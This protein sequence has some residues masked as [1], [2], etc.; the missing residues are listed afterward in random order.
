MTKRAK[1]GLFYL[2][3]LGSLPLGFLYFWGDVVSWVLKKVLK[4]RY[5]VVYTNLARSFPEKKYWELEPIADQFYTHL[6]ELFAE[7]VWFGGCYR[8]PERLRRQRL[9]EVANQELFNQVYEASPSVT[10]LTSHCGNWEILGGICY[11]NYN[12][13][14]PVIPQE[15]LYVAYKQLH[16]KVSDEIFY[17]N[18]RGV[19]TDYQGMLESN[20]IL[21]F[22][23]SHRKEKLAYF[24]I[25]DQYPDLMKAQLDGTFL[26]QTTYGMMGSFKLACKLS[27]AVL[28]A[29]SERV[30]RGNYR[31]VF[32]KICD[33]ASQYTPEQLMRMYFDHLEAEINSDPANWLWSHKRWK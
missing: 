12:E 1:I 2:R 28:Y 22:A 29:R 6:G 21:R 17:E 18:R 5:S 19:M 11:Y 23:L 4:Y 30:S 16:N 24:L 25:G 27:H 8:N 32:E 9:E 13:N 31:I 3:L 20:K 14:V 7:T 26:N 33:D 15:K 10:V